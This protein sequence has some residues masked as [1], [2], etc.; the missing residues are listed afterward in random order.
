MGEA[1]AILR[2]AGVF[3]EQPDNVPLNGTTNDITL[4]AR[5]TGVTLALIA[6]DTAVDGSQYLWESILLPVGRQVYFEANASGVNLGAAIQ[7]MVSLY[8][9]AGVLVPNSTLTI[10]STVSKRQRT[11]VALALADQTEYIVRYRTPGLLGTAYLYNARF[12]IR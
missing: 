1:R 5:Q 6:T 10:A 12:I 7:V 11:S 4:V 2:Q 9:S 8:T 3:R